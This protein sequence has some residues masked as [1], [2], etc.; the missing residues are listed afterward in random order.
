MFKDFQVDK[1]Q[2]EDAYRNAMMMFFLSPQFL[3]VDNK[4]KTKEELI[5]FSSYALLKSPPNAEYAKVYDQ[6]KKLRKPQISSE[7]LRKHHNFRR[8][9]SPFTYQWLKLGFFQMI[10]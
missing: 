7:Y 4:P 8:F 1:L 5:R 3:V 9:I 2:Y 6:A 10:F